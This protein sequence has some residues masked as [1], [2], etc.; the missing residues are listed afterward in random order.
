MTWILQKDD[1]IPMWQLLEIMGPFREVNKSPP[2]WA[3]M[4]PY[5]HPKYVWTYYPS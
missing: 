3:H 1:V 5:V 4:E 2:V